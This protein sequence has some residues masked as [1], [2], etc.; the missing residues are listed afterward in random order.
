MGPLPVEQAPRNL[1]HILQNWHVPNEPSD[2]SSPTT[3]S[4]GGFFLTSNLIVR[5]F[6]H[7]WT[8]DIFNM[9]KSFYNSFT[10]MQIWTPFQKFAFYYPMMK[11]IILTYLDCN[12]HLNDFY[13]MFLLFFNVIGRV[14]L[15]ICKSGPGARRSG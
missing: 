15:R 11:N 9:F 3:H 2:S 13:S 6:Y 12:N 14:I 8:W 10:C 5:K 1:K 4:P 7:L